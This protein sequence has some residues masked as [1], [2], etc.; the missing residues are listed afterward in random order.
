[1]KQS[2]EIIAGLIGNPNC[3]KT[4]LF[5]S[6]TG[7]NQHVGNFPGITVDKKTG[8]VKLPNSTFIELLD[9]PGCYSLYP[10]SSDEKV[11]VDVLSNIDN[12]AYPDFIIYIV[13]ATDM[14]RQFLLAS[15]I[16]DLGLPILMVLTMKDLADERG[17][18]FDLPMIEKE[19]GFPV[20]FYS[21]KTKENL[22]E[23]KDHLFSYRKLLLPE[24]LSSPLEKKRRWLNRSISNSHD[25]C[26]CCQGESC[27]LHNTYMKSI[28]SLI[29]VST[30]NSYYKLSQTESKLI[31]SCGDLLKSN[32]PYQAL[33]Q[34]QHSSWLNHLSTEVK[35]KIE[36]EKKKL[37]FNS[38]SAQI[39]ETL[40]RYQKFTPVIKK[41]VKV[42]RPVGLTVT[43]KIDQVITHKIMGPFLFFA[44]MFLVFQGIFSWAKY[45]M[46]L[47]EY[48]FNALS[49]WTASV[50]PAGWFSDLLVEGVLAGV[51][52]VMVF[53]PQIF[54]LF[55]MIG[56]MEEIGY[57]S[58]VVYMFDQL[59]QR[60]GLNGR[61]LV[62]LI[63][64]GAC[65]IPAIMSARTIGDKKERLITILVTPLISCSA[66]IPVYTILIGFAVP[67][68]NVGP[69]N[70][71]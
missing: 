14:D 54:F 57:M 41:A 9:F 64:G 23:I 24:K 58:R 47:I 65:A 2:N 66:R 45:P 30:T 68:M 19:F 48:A 53:I 55:L 52:G 42:P 56:I 43:D 32:T 39:E 15:Q 44:L 8:I 59:M 46:D 37:N 61:S 12:E 69:F 28:G 71:R 49:N 1:M 67:D 51:G 13:D 63:S 26:N 50:L 4:S 17:L 70:A 38:I 36:E 10:S 40:F 29:E 7:L 6:L 20:L 25:N 31:E 60:F 22:S 34:V 27:E 35:N 21:N 16:R 5:N 18:K 33:I 11:V 3:G 62:S